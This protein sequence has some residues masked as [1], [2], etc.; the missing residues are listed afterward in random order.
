MSKYRLYEAGDEAVLAKSH[1]AVCC[2]NNLPTPHLAHRFFLPKG[3]SWAG[4]FTL[5][6]CKRLI[7]YKW[8][9]VEGILWKGQGEE[10]GMRVCLEQGFPGLKLPQSLPSF[11]PYG[12]QRL[13]EIMAESRNQNLQPSWKDG[14][15]VRGASYSQPAI[16]YLP[17]S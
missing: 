12:T 1:E 14:G 17:E 10:Q 2:G 8:L 4:T 6:P 9:K 15:W 5:I 7:S 11:G 3:N 13:G 16:L